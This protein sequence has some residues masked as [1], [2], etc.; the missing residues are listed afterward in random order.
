[1]VIYAQN[2]SVAVGAVLAAGWTQ[3]SAHFT[4]GELADFWNVDSFKIITDNA[5]LSAADHRSGL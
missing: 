2:T 3:A 4:V 5:F 1:V